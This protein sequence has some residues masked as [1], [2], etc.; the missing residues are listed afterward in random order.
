MFLFIKLR[1][2]FFVRISILNFRSSIIH[3]YLIQFKQKSCIFIILYWILIFITRFLWF[4]AFSKVY[5]K[6]KPVKLEIILFTQFLLILKIKL[7]INSLKI[8]EMIKIS[9]M[10]MNI[11]QLIK[12]L[13]ICQNSRLKSLVLFFCLVLC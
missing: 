3:C 12:S 1:C 13:W 7:A 8:F 4:P 9:F 5:C 10:W 2:F 11:E 6:T